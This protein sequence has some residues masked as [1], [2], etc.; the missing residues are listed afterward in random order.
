MPARAPVPRGFFRSTIVITQWTPASRDRQGGAT[1]RALC[2]RIRAHESAAWK[3]KRERAFDARSLVK[4][5]LLRQ[6]R[7]RWPEHPAYFG[8][9]AGVVGAG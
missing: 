2:I 1:K 5:T 8:A 9:S 6:L 3:T 7:F 4:V